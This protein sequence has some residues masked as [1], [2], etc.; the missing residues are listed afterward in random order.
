[1]SVDEREVRELGVAREARRELAG[2]VLSAI[3]ATRSSI[4]AT[5]PRTTRA[6]SRRAPVALPLATVLMTGA[7]RPS[8]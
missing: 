4:P 7:G 2:R 8:P 5:T 6:P 3:G 1:M